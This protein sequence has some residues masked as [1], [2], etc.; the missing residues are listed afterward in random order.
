MK[1]FGAVAACFLLSTTTC[2]AQ[3]NIQGEDGSTVTIGPGGI[4]INGRGPGSK[5]NVKLGP[6]GIQIDSNDG[7]R[8]SKVNL[9]P[10][11]NVQT[12]RARTTK[13]V[14]T[15]TKRVGGTIVKS[16]TVNTAARNI[17]PS[18]PSAEEQVTIIETKIYGQSHA[19][20]PLIAR[21][22]KLEIDN[23]GQKGSG[24][25]TVRINALAK[26]LG[27]TL[28]GTSTTIV[29]SGN[30]TVEI[31]SPAPEAMTI[32]VREG[33]APHNSIAIGPELS[34]MVINESNQTIK[35]HC[36]GNSIVLNGNNCLLQ[37]SGKLGLVT[38]NGNNNR[39]TSESIG[40]VVA[41]GN[42]N[43]VT[44]S[45]PHGAPQ[46]SNNGKDNAMHAQ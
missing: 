38:I 33:I 6:G 21:V 34:N 31:N 40:L 5:A 29:N 11:M 1:V 23:L 22:E 13:T 28:T 7:Y 19:G 17:K 2:L 37:L 16:T 39:I 41:N 35:G 43:N 25:L 30:S 14:T 4:N 8:R 9:G 45:H 32:N 10:G 20:R 36:N 18:G 42:S 26:Q 27:V 12:N 46:I 3:I 44:W 15:T 24:P